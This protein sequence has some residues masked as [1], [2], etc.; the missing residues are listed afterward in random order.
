MISNVLA[1]VKSALDSW[2]NLATGFGTS[3]DKSAQTYFCFDTPLSNFELAGLYTFDDIAGK[4]VDASP[5]EEFREPFGLKG[6]DPEKTSAVTQY[7]EPFNLGAVCTEGRIWGRCFGG[8]ATYI[9]VEDG[10][11]PIEPLDLTRIQSVTALDTIDMRYLNPHRYYTDGPKAGQVV[12]YAVQTL[13]GNGSASRTIGYVH[14]TRLVMWPGARTEMQAKIQR[15]LWDYSV[16]QKPYNALKSAGNTWKAIEALTVDA[17][18]AVYKIKDLWRMIVADPLQG[19]DSQTG[20]GPSG[21]LLKRIQFMDHVRSAMR[22]IVLDAEGEDFTRTTTSFAGLPDLSDKAWLRVAAAADMPVTILTGQSPA[23]LQATGASDLR[24]W[25]GKVSSEQQQIDEPRI[26][27]ILRILF[28]AK[29]APKL[30]A[31]E[32]AS[33]AVVWVPLW[34]PT[35]VELEEMKLKAIQGAQILIQEQVLTPEEWLLSSPP[36]WFQAANREQRE[37]RMLELSEAGPDEQQAATLQ[38]TPTDIAAVVTV[39]Q[40]LNSVGLPPMAG[41]DGETTVEAYRAKAQADAAPKP[42]PGA[43]PRLFG[44]LDHVD[45]WEGLSKRQQAMTRW[46]ERHDDKDF[47]IAW[48]KV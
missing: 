28:A 44:R 34:A 32:L 47:G 11:D 25:N 6:F 15:N 36:D 1:G 17:N 42:A 3:R 22:A 27:Q 12:V 48:G 26:K 39:N 4:I 7:L 46:V 31:G 13:T 37:A 20:N 35:S 21:G 45:K 16:L 33:I 8:C 29:T 38:L 2:S 41:P 5:R 10:L 14:E 24:W 23:G 18:Q 30:D 40:A 9:K 43:A 19:Q